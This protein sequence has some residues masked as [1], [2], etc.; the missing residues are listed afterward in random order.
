MSRVVRS[1]GLVERISYRSTSSLLR[2]STGEDILLRKNIFALVLQ[3]IKSSLF[4]P[5]D[6]DALTGEYQYLVTLVDERGYPV[7]RDFFF[8][9]LSVLA[10]YQSRRFLSR[11]TDNPAEHNG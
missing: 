7:W 4:R 2:S 10:P 11:E 5:P 8:L 9:H 3:D 1:G 6:R